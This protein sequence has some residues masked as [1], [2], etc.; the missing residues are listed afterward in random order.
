MPADYS[1]SRAARALLCLLAA[2]FS[3]P[4]GAMLRAQDS[5]VVRIFDAHP[6]H[7]G[8]SAKY[9]TG[10]IFGEEGGRII[11]R[12]L[13]LPAFSGPVQIT[14]RVLVFST[15][16]EG[17]DGDPWDR[18]GAVMLTIPGMENIELLK[19]ITGFGGRSDLR[20]DVSDLASLLSGRRTIRGFVDTWVSPA[21]KITFDLIYKPVTA[22]ANPAW[23]NGVYHNW[24]MTAAQ[25]SPDKPGIAVN[26]PPAAERV[27]LT[28]YTSGHCTDGTDA[29][30]FVSKD[31]VISIDGVEVYR[32]KPWRSDCKNFRT[33]NPRSGR[34]GNT[35]S[36]DLSRSGWCPG[37]IVYPLRLDLSAALTPGP[38]TLRCAVENIRPADASGTGYWRVSSYLS[39]NGQVSSWRADRIAL[40]FESGKIHPAGTATPVRIDL[41]D[42]SGLPVFVAAADIRVTASDPALLFSNDALVWGNPLEITITNGSAQIWMKSSAALQ[43]EFTA[44]DRSGLLA[45]PQPLAVTF[46]DFEVGPDE[47]NLALAA[48]ARAD[49]ECNSV[50]ENA[51]KAIDGSLATKWCCNNGAPDWLEVTLPDTTAMNYFIV[52]HAGAGQA[53]AGDPGAGDG[54]GMNSTDF[55]IQLL[56]SAGSWRNAISVN[57]NPGDQSGSVSYHA[58]PEKVQSRQVR[59]YLTKPDVS[60]IYEFEIYHRD[61]SP[62]RLDEEAEGEMPERMELA[63][64]WPNPFNS[65]AAIRI[66]V[67]ELMEVRA[68]IM[69]NRGQLVAQVANGTLPRG[70]HTFHWQ[71]RNNAG[72]A[73]ASGIYYINVLGIDAAGQRSLQVRPVTLVR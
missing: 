48:T 30:E 20:Q 29:D 24:G 9:D 61:A 53:P 22:P 60:R 13:D 64:A 42:D 39:G 2:L 16:Q 10:S 18:A 54:P 58:L 73:A 33:R 56:D 70:L 59:L 17:T 46:Y 1:S 49:C 55:T 57:D 5:T 51:G 19:F 43:T 15:L 14:A 36:S 67:P 26:I 72:E 21:W 27:W 25:V 47:V 45:G 66:F 71:G 3:F 38:H 50:S 63:A 23:A 7:F 65:S 31:N 40:S 44:A 35:W 68:A 52:R 62:V 8:E 6:I 41:V 4:D 11:R 32:Y 12:E 69:N 37:D 34:W 28:Y